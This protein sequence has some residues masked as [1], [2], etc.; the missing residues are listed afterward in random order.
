MEHPLRKRLTF[1]VTV[2]ESE[3]GD[4]NL[5]GKLQVVNNGVIRTFK[6]I[7]ELD[8]QIREFLK[9]PD[10]NPLYPQVSDRP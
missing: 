5:H 10:S 2:L 8:F 6:N 4:E 1:L 7:N 9:R 3:D